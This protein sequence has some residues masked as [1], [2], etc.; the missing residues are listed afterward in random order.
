MEQWTGGA[1]AIEDDLVEDG[2][3]VL[4][5]GIESSV[6]AFTAAATQWRWVSFGFADP[7]RVGLDYAG[8]RAAMALAAIAETPELFEDIRIMEGAALAAFGEG[9][10]P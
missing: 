7:L 3:L 1:P 8:L 9:V 4:P 5:A 6:R 2:R 10:K